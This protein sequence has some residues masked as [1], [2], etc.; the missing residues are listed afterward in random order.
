MVVYT[1]YCWKYYMCTKPLFQNYGII[2]WNLVCMWFH[3]DMQPFLLL[4]YEL[5]TGSGWGCRVSKQRHRI[6]HHDGRSWQCLRDQ[7]RHWRNYAQAVHQVNGDRAKHHQG[8]RLQMVSGG[9]SQGQ[10]L[11]ILQHNSS[12]QHRHHRGGKTC[13]CLAQHNAWA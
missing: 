5:S 12:G 6:L 10:G 9:P 3:W 4:A 1:I 13:S 11:A 2:Y 8:E 7:H